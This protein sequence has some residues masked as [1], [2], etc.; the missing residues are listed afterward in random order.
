MLLPRLAWV[1]GALV[2]TAAPT[3]ARAD[4]WGFAWAGR[5]DADGAPIFDPDSDSA[6]RRAAV[7]ALRSYDPSLTRKYVLKALT[8][9]DDEVRLEAARV[10]AQGRMVDAVPRLVEWLSDPDKVVRR[11]ATD[12]LGAIGDAAGTVALIRTLGDFDGDVRMGAVLALGKIGQRGDRT[13]VVPL[14][15]RVTDEKTEVRRAAIEA[16]KAIGDRRAVVAM[17]SAFGDPNLEVRKTAAG[18]VGKLGDRAA[19]PALIRLL[20]EPQPE[21]RHLA[22]TSLG[23]LGA[24][25]AVDDL[26]A[27]LARGGDSSS[28]AAY[29]LGQIAAGGDRD[30]TPIAVR[31]LVAALADPAGRP[32]V[33]EA[34]RRAGTAAVPA[35]VDHLDGRAPGDPGS[36]VDLLS[37]FGDARATPALIAELDRGRMGVARVVA[38]LA[39]T[40]DP[41][42]LVPVLGLIASPDPAIRIAA[43]TAT[44]PL[45]GTDRRAADALI[46]RL[47][48]DEE[49]VRVL[50]ADYLAQI[51][52]T[53]AVPALIGLTGAPR[54]ARLRHAAIAALGAMG[55]GQAGPALIA[56]LADPDPILARAAAD[57]LA[58]L[59]DPAT[60]RALAVAARHDDAT[61]PFVIRA[62]G[63]ALRDRPDAAA[64]KTL[65]DLAT[66]D[67][68]A[69]ALAAIGALAAMGDRAARPTLATLVAGASPERQRAA[70]WALGELADAT[71]TPAVTT[72]LVDALGSKDDR[73]ASAAAWALGLQPTATAA[74]PLRR[75]ARHGSWASSIN[76]TAALAHAGG[77]DAISDLTTLSAHRSIL[78]RGNAAW[79]L[80]ERAATLPDDAVAA[81]VRQLTDDASPWVRATAARA[82]QPLRTRP[83]VAAALAAAASDRNPAVVAAAATHSPSL[84]R[85]QWRIFDVVEPDDDRPVRE[86]P[87]FVVL[88]ATGPA[89]ATFTDRRGVIAAEHVP[90]DTLPP[91]PAATESEL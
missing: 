58:Y 71:P 89:W 25:E 24:A 28:S 87:Y 22:M 8:D 56:V 6:A 9:D 65:E 29:A 37:D 82:L 31:A 12:A 74:A 62:W 13:V 79:A 18:G 36:A 43:M 55:D 61:R 49:D 76:A 72:A 59:G 38:A 46:E 64:R 10:A 52:A 81:L 77:P 14:I 4:T 3:A 83:A 48:D 42:A 53:T 7:S 41:R 44:G 30:A 85:D 17:V 1:L 19:I 23:D 47:G 11:V 21:L 70:A 60:E 69:T 57:A 90:A 66:L 2:A 86:E 27:V 5:I 50:A 45:L 80:G 15:S 20:N 32:G 39:R 67:G 84:P 54:S 63:A 91:R 26:V 34:L 33:L 73:V 78:V 40:R 16:L 88:G 68:P 75:L 35:L 51:R